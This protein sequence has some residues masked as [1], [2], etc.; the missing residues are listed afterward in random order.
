MRR[1]VRSICHCEEN[2]SKESEESRWWYG[3]KLAVGK[4]EEKWPN[5]KESGDSEEDNGRG[6]HQTKERGKSFPYK[7]S[8]FD[9]SESSARDINQSDRKVEGN[10]PDLGNA[11]KVRSEED[12][13]KSIDAAASDH[14][15]WQVE[16]V[17]LLV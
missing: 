13:E 2:V 8:S 10:G 15:Q 7:S 16:Y 17:F 5:D 4:V 9:S 1:S 12:E 6:R 3:D 14:T 11:E